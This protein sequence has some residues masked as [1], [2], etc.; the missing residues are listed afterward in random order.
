M[1]RQ[2]LFLYFE[3]LNERRICHVA[4]RYEDHMKSQTPK[5]AAY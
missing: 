4:E 3:S 2:S 1:N 5:E